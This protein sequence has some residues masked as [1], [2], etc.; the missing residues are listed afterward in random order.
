MNI[1]QQNFK[2]KE[3]K[4]LNDFSCLK[5]LKKKLENKLCAQDKSIQF[6]HMMHTPCKLCDGNSEKTIDIPTRFALEKLK[7]PYHLFMMVM[8]SSSLITFQ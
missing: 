5:T 4:L 7:W 6:V 2:Q 3:N 8:R 1:L